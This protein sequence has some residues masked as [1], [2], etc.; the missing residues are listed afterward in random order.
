MKSKELLNN[1]TLEKVSGPLTLG[2][3]RLFPEVSLPATFANDSNL[4]KRV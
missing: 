2:M 3:Y 1:Q 4:W